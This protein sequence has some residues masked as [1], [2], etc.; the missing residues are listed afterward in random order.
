MA[1]QILNTGTTNNDKSGD[2]LRAGGLKIKANFDEIYAALA[3]D[4]RNISGGDL[5]KTASY[6]DLRNLPDFKEISTTASFN[7]LVDVPE[8]AQYIVMPPDTP[9]GADGDK[10]GNISSDAD[11]VYLCIADYTQQPTFGPLTFQHEENSIDFSLQAATSDNDSTI[12][13][14]PGLL[15]PS[16][17]WTVTDGTTTRT[18]TLVTEIGDGNNGIWYECSLDGQFTSVE[19]T[20][21][22]IA[23]APPNGGFVACFA[24][25]GAYQSLVDAHDQGLL[26][27]KLFKMGD[28]TGRVITHVIH[29]SIENELTI[30][31]V[32][33]QFTN[34]TGMYVIEDQ[35][36]IWKV[37]PLNAASANLGLFKIQDNFLGTSAESNGWGGSDMYLSPNGEG[38]SYIYIPNDN[39]SNNG[40]PTII[41][42][43]SSNGGGVQISANNGNWQFVSDG[44]LI[45]PTNG[46]IKDNYNNSIS[47]AQVHATDIFTIE[48]GMSGGNIQFNGYIDNGMGNDSGATLHV[49][50]MI[51][52]TLT[53]GMQIYGDSLPPEGWTLTFTQWPGAGDGGTGLYELAGANFLTTGEVFNDGSTST[54]KTWTFDNSGRTKLPHGANNP[55]TARGAA[56]DKAGMMLVSG[57]Y[58]YY[59][60]A[61]YTD[62]SVPI[63]Q[64]VSMDN[65]DWD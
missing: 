3:N 28:T 18:I 29:D 39:N 57:A 42:N 41:G 51:A 9:I 50:S 52:G 17:D 40:A 55:T 56:G 11:Y 2:T 32:G 5:L 38:Y 63:W 19:N 45:L 7:D 62:G 23:F 61:D 47:P 4:G 30:A 64:K 14:K 26:N 37:I 33:D 34:W 60:Y 12:V 8:L 16:V 22:E 59:C 20:Y 21:Y 58:L 25:S 24:W 6:T 54:V 27:A 31:Y 49:T 1:K 53:N 35:P 46:A 43:T 13:L 48:S 36:E 10:R 44:V 15:T 65:T